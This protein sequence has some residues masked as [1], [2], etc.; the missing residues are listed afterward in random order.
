LTNAVPAGPH[1][2]S[3]CFSVT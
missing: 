1:E 2:L 3:F